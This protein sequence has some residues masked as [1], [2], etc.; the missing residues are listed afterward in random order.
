MPGANIMDVD[1]GKR[2]FSA[3]LDN[4]AKVQFGIH[5]LHRLTLLHIAALI[6]SAFDFFLALLPLNAGPG[7]TA[8]RQSGHRRYWRSRDHYEARIMGSGFSAAN[9]SCA[10]TAS[11]ISGKGMGTF[12]TVELTHVISINTKEMVEFLRLVYFTT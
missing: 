3:P 5:L 9:R 4:S 10:S 12:L 6:N 2:T 8:G 11:W 7:G 1:M